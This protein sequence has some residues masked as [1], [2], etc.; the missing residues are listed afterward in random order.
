MVKTWVLDM[1]VVLKSL[2]PG[3]EKVRIMITPKPILT[4]TSLRLFGRVLLD[5]VVLSKIVEVITGVG[6][7]FAPTIHL[8]TSLVVSQRMFSLTKVA[9]LPKVAFFK[10][11]LNK[12]AD[13]A[14]T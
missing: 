13:D 1:P 9:F 6:I 10:R 5:L 12:L 3:T 7:L 4:L 11:F 8:E 2:K 14:R